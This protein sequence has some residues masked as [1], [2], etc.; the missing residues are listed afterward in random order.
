MKALFVILILVL[1]GCTKYV[2]EKDMG[3]GVYT[4]V[5]V[6]STRDLEQPVV[7]YTRTG[8]DATFDFSAASVDSNTEIFMGSMMQMM[9]LMQQIMLTMPADK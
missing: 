9:Q 5:S 6:S 8:Q 2:V 1:S 7:R 4:K 3:D